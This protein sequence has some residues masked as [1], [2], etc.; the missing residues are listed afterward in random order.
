M[1]Q[2]VA[3]FD[4]LSFCSGSV[5]AGLH[6]VKIL[7]SLRLSGLDARQIAVEYK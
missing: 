6:L 1:V 3:V 7:I 4:T 5:N 2:L